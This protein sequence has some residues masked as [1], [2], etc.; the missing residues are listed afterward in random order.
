M[1]CVQEFG[2]APLNGYLFVPGDIQHTLSEPILAP[3]YAGRYRFLINKPK[4]QEVTHR[5]AANRVEH[6]VPYYRTGYDGQE[7][8]A[9]Q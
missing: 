4:A 1:Y 8:Y 5:H 2:A 6:A 3:L 9:R 7:E